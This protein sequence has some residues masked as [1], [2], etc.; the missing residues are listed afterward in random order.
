M[1][2]AVVIYVYV[3]CHQFVN[4]DSHALYVFIRP[5]QIIAMGYWW[6][7]GYKTFKGPRPNLQGLADLKAQ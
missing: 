6:F 1:N 7:L 3:R 2:W 5:F 4:L